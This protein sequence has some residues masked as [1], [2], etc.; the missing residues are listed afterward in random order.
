MWMIATLDGDSRSEVA[1]LR[2]IRP[3]LTTFFSRRLSND[4]STVEDLVQDVLV[5]VHQRRGSYD[6][7]RPFSPWLFAVAR[8]KMVDYFRQYRRHEPLDDFDDRLAAESFQASSDARMDV[9]A[10]LGTL[11]AKQAQAIRHTR[12]CELSVVEAARLAGIG[13]SDVKVSAH[14]GIKALSALVARC[15]V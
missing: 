1:L 6:R 2:A 7:S 13:E 10:L 11:P 14:R 3:V 12:L 9:T 15:S 4:P 8:H 5:A